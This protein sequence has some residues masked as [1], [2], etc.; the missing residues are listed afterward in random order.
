VRYRGDATEQDAKNLGK[1][2]RTKG[3]FQNLGEF[4]SL[5]K[6]KSGAFVSFD[7]KEATWDKPSVVAAFEELG[8]EIAPVV[9]VYPLRV[10]FGYQAD[11]GDDSKTHYQFMTTIAIAEGRR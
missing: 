1:A 7:V 10:E 4:V 11:S 2:L 9:G 8:R 3:Y 5:T 6:D